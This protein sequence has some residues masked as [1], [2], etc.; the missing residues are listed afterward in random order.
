M[1]TGYEFLIISNYDHLLHTYVGRSSKVRCPIKNVIPKVFRHTPL[2]LNYEDGDIRKHIF[3]E[4]NTQIIIQFH[5][6][7]QPYPSRR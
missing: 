2:K 6:L 1:V 5:T 7:Y 4:R 3:S